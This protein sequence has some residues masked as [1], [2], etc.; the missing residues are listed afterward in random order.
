MLVRRFRRGAFLLGF[1]VLV[2]QTLP[3]STSGGYEGALID[4]SAVLYAD[5]GIEFN[6]STEASV[7]MQTS[8]SAG[9]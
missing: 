6:T 4:Q 7:Q 3:G 8:P 1:P 2:S 9:A 5:E